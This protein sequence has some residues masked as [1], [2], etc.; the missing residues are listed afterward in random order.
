MA[1]HRVSLK[2]NGKTT[3]QVLTQGHYNRAMEFKWSI[4]FEWQHHIASFILPSCVTR[5]WSLWD[6]DVVSGVMCWRYSREEWARFATFRFFLKVCALKISLQ[7]TW[8][9]ICSCRLWLQHAGGLVAFVQQQVHGT[10]THSALQHDIIKPLKMNC[11]IDPLQ[12]DLPW[13]KYR[14]CGTCVWMEVYIYLSP[15]TQG[16]G[17]SVVMSSARV[18]CFGGENEL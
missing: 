4:A 1:W 3:Q 11:N 5:R 12:A 13:V 7:R 18:E 9:L 2:P 10:I 6:W 16:H 17:S 8:R 14:R 15:G